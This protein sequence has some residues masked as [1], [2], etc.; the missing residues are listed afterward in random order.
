MAKSTSD[1]SRAD[2]TAAAQS[3][4]QAS[5]RRRTLL[6]GA[7]LG[8][9]LGGGLYLSYTLWLKP[10]DPLPTLSLRPDNV[11]LQSEFL[12]A[13]KAVD[14]YRYEIRTHPEVVSNYVQLAQL[15][16]QEARVTA[17][18]HEYLPKAKSLLDQAL[19]KNPN[20]FEALAA[21]AS[22]QMTLHRFK[23]A[24]EFAERA[25]AQ[26]AYS[27]FAYGVLC[28]A[29][30]ELGAYGEAVAVSDKLQSLRP[31][32]RAYARVSY[33][34]ELHG[35]TEGACAA[36]KLAADAGVS[37][38]ED[39]AWTLY[40]LGILH[41]QQGR[42]DT[43]EFIFKGV[44]EERENYAFAHA[45]LSKVAAARG[46]LPDATL[47]L[48]KAMQT[49][50]DHVFIEQLADLYLAQGQTDAAA[51]LEKKVLDAF[52]QHES[53]GWSTDH[54]YAAFCLSHNLNAEESLRRAK[55]DYDYRPKNIDA[56]ETYAHALCKNNR[57]AEAAPVMDEALRLGTARATLH[58]HAAVVF[59]EAGQ[60]AKALEALKK[61]AASHIS[62]YPLYAEDAKKRLHALAATA[63]LP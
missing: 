37:G 49:V 53:G 22:M 16:L 9:L 38:F 19:A 15:F 4:A 59:Q 63:E 57:A 58:Y 18:H 25:L 21:T 12:N 2:A 46:N 55:R 31:D 41:L 6:F 23:E 60:S 54:E 42:L 51:E 29:L 24:K 50:P 40:Q 14:H 10:A 5:A 26:N 43:A 11:S 32:L 47:R 20:D 48:V 34:R 27:A 7:A 36:M 44:L 52:A 3:S 28:D 13:Q 61:A 1:P 35:D 30:T 45:G 39:R 56:L 62:L 8:L 33:L 17:N